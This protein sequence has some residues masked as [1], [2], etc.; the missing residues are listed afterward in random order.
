MMPRHGRD[1]DSL[2]HAINPHGE[3][4]PMCANFPEMAPG[5]PCVYCAAWS[6]PADRAL[7]NRVRGRFRRLAERRRA[8]AEQ[9]A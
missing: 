1:A 9:A 4:C 3:R 5:R 6:T 8:R 2:R 7:A